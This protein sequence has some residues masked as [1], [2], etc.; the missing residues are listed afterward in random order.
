MISKDLPLD[1]EDQ[2][3]VR[4]KEGISL[5]STK[6]Q[7]L[8][9]ITSDNQHALFTKDGKYLIVKLIFIFKSN[10]HNYEIYLLIR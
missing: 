9:K 8:Q 3:M 7:N 2:I 1:L 4:S 10:N 5:F 6:D